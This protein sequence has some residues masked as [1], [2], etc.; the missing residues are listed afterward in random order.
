MKEKLEEAVKG[1]LYAHLRYLTFA[2]RAQKRGYEKVANLMRA[3]ADSSIAM[4]AAFL[5]FW[6]SR[7]RL[8]RR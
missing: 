1:E 8:W 5:L 7:C 4:H 2:D 6:N 3:L